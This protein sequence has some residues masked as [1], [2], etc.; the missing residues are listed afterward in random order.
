[1]AEHIF[2]LLRE[3]LAQ[4]GYWAVAA[5]LLLENAG[6]P[7]PG[8]AVLLTASFLAFSEKRLSL[9]YI[10]LTG[11]GAATLGDNLG[12]LIGYYG[13]RRLLARYGAI[14]RLRA[15][16]VERGEALFAHYGAATVLMARFVAGLR[17]IAGPLAGVLRMHWRKFVL[18]NFIGAVL[19]VTAISCAGFF[20]GRH[21][22][23]LM[24][25]FR[26][27]NLGFLVLGALAVLVIW[28]RATR[29][30]SP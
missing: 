8:E 22:Q 3:S 10:I 18:F 5:V 29:K 12:F 28:W 24:Q 21:W 15:S 13:G 6:I 9:P 23:R 16:T 30:K 26:T 2:H 4:Y 27:V 17:V 14:L 25:V 1:M 7:V 11:T 20:F 19:W